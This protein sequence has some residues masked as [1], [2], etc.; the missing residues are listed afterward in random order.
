MKSIKTSL[1]LVAIGLVFAATAIA[2][3]PILDTGPNT[4]PGRVDE[5]S[6]GSLHALIPLQAAPAPASLEERARFHLEAA[7]K[8]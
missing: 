6:V 2:G 5:S 1:L 7:A 8:R 3:T 4:T